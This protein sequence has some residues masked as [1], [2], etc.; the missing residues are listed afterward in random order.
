M[1]FEHITPELFK[2][3]E[4]I[5]LSLEP[6]QNQNIPADEIRLLFNLHNKVYWQNMEHSTACGGCR[7]RVWNRLKTWYYDNKDSFTEKCINL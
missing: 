7:S 6:R 2:Q 3:V 1:S 4:Q 5:I